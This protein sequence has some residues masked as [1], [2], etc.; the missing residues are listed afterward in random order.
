M[1][2]PLARKCLNTVILSEAKNLGSWKFTELQR[3]FG[4]EGASG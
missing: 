2:A 4:A 3:S 1:R